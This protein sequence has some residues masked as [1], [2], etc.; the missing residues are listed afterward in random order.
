[1]D[2]YI[3]LEGTF[4]FRDIGGFDTADGRQVRTGMLFRSDALYRLS[5]QDLKTLQEMGLRTVVDFRSP[6]EAAAHPNRL[7]EGVKTVVLAP[8]AELA[9][10][11][12]ASHGDDEA[13]VNKMVEQAKT[14]EGREYFNN[15]LD[16]MEGQMRSFV[17]GES[18]I[19]AYSALLHLLLEPDAPPLVF[20]CKGGKDRTGW[21]AALILSLLGV[22]RDEIVADYLKTAEYNTARNAKRMDQYRKYTDNQFVLGFLASLMQ[23]KESYISACFEE[24]DQAGGLDRYLHEVL[25]VTE[26]EVMMLKE[27]YLK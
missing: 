9:A 4:N 23:V 18:G 14:A 24:I 25:K 27:I 11:A 21:A 10:Q 19:K 20:H 5:D 8:H 26:K 6:S 2:R 17:T 16:S 7:P 13:K 1:M 15:N 3:P 12:S 22:S